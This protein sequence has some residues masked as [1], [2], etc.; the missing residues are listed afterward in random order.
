MSVVYKSPLHR[1]LT[2]LDVP[3]G[4][5]PVCAGFDSRNVLCVWLWL[6][7]TDGARERR[8]F[9]TAQTG[10]PIKLGK[11]RHVDSDK[12]AEGNLYHVFEVEGP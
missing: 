3:V 4:S 9:L 7:K 10:E 6:P 1:V 11:L 2:E 5:I 8:R 12:S